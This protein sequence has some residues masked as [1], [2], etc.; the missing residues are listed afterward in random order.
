MS[1]DSADGAGVFIGYLSTGPGELDEVLEI[2][3]TVLTRGAA[4]KA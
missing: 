3:R 2:Y 4:V 1:H